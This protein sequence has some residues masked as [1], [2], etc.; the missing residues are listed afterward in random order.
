MTGALIFIDLEMEKVGYLTISEHLQHPEQLNTSQFL[1][2]R[3]KV[4][5]HREKRTF[6][7]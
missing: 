4:A 1:H 7:F 6:F 2:D 5:S 3:Y